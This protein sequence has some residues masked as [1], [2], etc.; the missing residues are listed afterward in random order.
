M[1]MVAKDILRLR[2]VWDVHI[3]SYV[4]LCIRLTIV[5]LSVWWP[6]I[7]EQVCKVSADSRVTKYG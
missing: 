1:Q 2:L 7:I 6:S 5:E 4:W 3:A